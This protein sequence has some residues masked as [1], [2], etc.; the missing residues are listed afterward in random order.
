MYPRDVE[1]GIQYTDI[2][3]I[4]SRNMQNYSLLKEVGMT[5]HPI[6]LKRGM[7]S[8]IDEFILAAEYIVSNGN[9]NV[10]MCERGIQTFENRVCGKMSIPLPA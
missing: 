6:L 7:M 1:E 8:T 4:G 10:I 2:I 9:K 5:E 3:Q